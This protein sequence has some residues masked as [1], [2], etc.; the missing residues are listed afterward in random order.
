MGK[1]LKYFVVEIADGSHPKVLPGSRQCLYSVCQWNAG[2]MIRD[3]AQPDFQK[4]D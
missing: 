1:M 2:S 4:N 3:I